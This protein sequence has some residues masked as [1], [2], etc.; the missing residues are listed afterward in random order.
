[1]LLLF[2]K[3]GGW[4]SPSATV[5]THTPKQWHSHTRTVEQM[6]GTERVR[7]K[8]VRRDGKERRGRRER[9]KAREP[10]RAGYVPNKGC[11]RRFFTSH[12]YSHTRMHMYA[13]MCV[14]I[15]VYS[16]IRIA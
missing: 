15:N 10:R 14:R 2:W 6:V 3:Q 4:Q 1:M 12:V 5:V 16:S 7:S 9:G 13:D 8:C 11:S